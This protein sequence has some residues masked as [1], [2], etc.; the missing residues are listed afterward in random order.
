VSATEGSL[1]AATSVA[2]ATGLQ[3]VW[4][5]ERIG[6]AGVGGGVLL[7]AAVAVAAGRSPAG[8]P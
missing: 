3:A 4:L 1:A 8:A 5:G 6:A 2:V 7:L